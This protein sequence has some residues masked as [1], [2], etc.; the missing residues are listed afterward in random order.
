ML[1]LRWR[2]FAIALAINAAASASHAGDS[3]VDASI[4]DGQ[5]VEKISLAEAIKMSL[6]NN[7]EA[8]FDRVGVRIQRSRVRFEAGAFD[9]VF[10]MNLGTESI[11]RPE[12]SNIFSSSQGILQ[13]ETNRANQ[14][15]TNAIR[16]QQGLPPIDRNDIRSG[17]ADTI[18]DQQN[19]RGSANI[20]GRTPWGMRYGFFAEA[21]RLRN[22][23][24]G[25]QRE[26]LPDYQTSVGIQIAQPLL[27]DFGPAAALA[28]L[29]ISRIEQK[30]AVL[31]WRQRVMSGVQAVMS[32]YYDMIFGVAD[33]QVRRDAIAADTKLVQQNQRRL[34]LG[35]MSPFDVEQ[36]RAQVSLDKEQFLTAKNFLNERQFALKRLILDE[37][38]RGDTRLFLPADSPRL[39][40]PKLDRSALLAEAFARRYDYQEALLD[41]EAQDVRLRF[42]RNQALPQLDLIAT[43]SLNGLRDSFG[44]SFD[45]AAQGRTPEWTVG[46]N[47]RVPLGNVQGRA[48]L[49]VAK[50]QKEQAVIKIKQIELTV[51]VDVDTVISR[52][53]TNRQRVDTARNTSAL[54]QEAVR[55][56]YRRLEEGQISSFDII[57]QQRRLYDA[58]S[59][60]L[61]SQA[62]LNKAI[63]QLW[64]VTG[65]IL[66]K[67][68]ISFEPEPKR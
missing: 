30:I 1:N 56:A 45:Q 68:G 2:A 14:D 49:D 34:E 22:T 55:I 65:T 41:A 23:F 24:S 21:N 51:G 15:L 39:Q 5:S 32:T 59:R 13:Q 58:R 20:I 18:F 26:I 36:A 57:E 61:A 47:V 50:A 9:P 25:D 43:Y 63:T 35:F 17:T 54:N 46:L 11:R 10:S 12:N 29:R 27:K 4:F 42:A 64:L 33:L 67:T 48:N 52:I 31:N 44:A 40:A 3:S 19:N 62:E 53:E 16:T 6:S 28:P 66:E 37:F 7:L 38:K 8:R 60:E